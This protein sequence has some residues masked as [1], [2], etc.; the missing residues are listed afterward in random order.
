VGKIRSQWHD[1]C[2]L[3]LVI[4]GELNG[5]VE[6]SIRRQ[7]R[8]LKGWGIV[9]L[10]AGGEHS[11]QLGGAHH[12]QFPDFPNVMSAVVVADVPLHIRLA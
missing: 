7:G 8:G 3:N 2:L 6:P 9:W 4:V 1:E 12:L 5:G 11:D 10:P